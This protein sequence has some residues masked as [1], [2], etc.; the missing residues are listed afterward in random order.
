M[1]ELCQTCIMED[2]IK[3]ERERERERETERERERR[4]RRR[5]IFSLSKENS[6]WWKTKTRGSRRSIKVQGRHIFNCFSEI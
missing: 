1:S 3:R 2:K 4:R 6:E 5:R